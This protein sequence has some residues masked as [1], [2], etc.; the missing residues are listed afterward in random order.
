MTLVEEMTQHEFSGGGKMKSLGCLVLKFSCGDF[1]IHCLYA[2]PRG[3][4]Y[5]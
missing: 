1:L 3:K 5:R 4:M 2:T